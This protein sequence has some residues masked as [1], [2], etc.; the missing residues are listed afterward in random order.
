MAA[1]GFEVMFGSLTITEPG[2]VEHAP[3]S[4][5]AQKAAALSARLS[6]P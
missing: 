1:L 5:A 3:T 4:S 6:L 2:S